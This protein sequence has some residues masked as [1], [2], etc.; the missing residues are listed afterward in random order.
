M[1]S[2]GSTEPRIELLRAQVERI[3]FSQKQLHTGA[4]KVVP[5]DTLILALG[6]RSNK[7]GWPGQDLDGVHGLFHW[8]DLEAMER[9]SA[10]LERAVIVGG[11]LFRHLSDKSLKTWKLER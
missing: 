11:G 7:F 2:V 9:H 3:D 10:G 5:Y 1:Y 8:Q 6:S 4:G